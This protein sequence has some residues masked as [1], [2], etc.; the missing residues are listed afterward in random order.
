ME[1]QI[2]IS[3]EEYKELIAKAERIA[4]VERMFKSEDYICTKDVLNALNITK[5]GEIR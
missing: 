2:I 3:V 4:V 5:G 1:H